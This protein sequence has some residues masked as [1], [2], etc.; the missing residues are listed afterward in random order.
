MRYWSAAARL[1]KKRLAAADR[2]ADATEDL[3]L[4][5]YA[6]VDALQTS[7]FD[8][9]DIDE[10]LKEFRAALPGLNGRD[11]SVSSVSQASHA[12]MKA[13]P[14]AALI[15]DATPTPTHALFLRRRL[16]QL[17]AAFA[18]LWIAPLLA[19]RNA[20]APWLLAPAIGLFLYRITVVMHDCTHHTLFESRKLKLDEPATRRVR[21]RPI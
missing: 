4:A 21:T 17:I 7:N 5:L 18:L 2:I 13:G 11:V 14:G 12:V 9:E 15:D 1:T 8:A 6:V 19:Q 20:L 10:S 16:L 3:N